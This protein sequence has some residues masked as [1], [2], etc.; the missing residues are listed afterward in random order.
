MTV[1]NSDGK[2]NCSYCGK[3][4]AYPQDADICRDGHE[5]IYV[6]LTK[7]DLSHI[8]TFMYTKDD[9]ILD[10]RLIKRLQAY[11]RKKSIGGQMIL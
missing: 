2:Y 6:A 1:K 7:E 10:E 5:L 3:E 11:Y 9:D 8:L 4:Y